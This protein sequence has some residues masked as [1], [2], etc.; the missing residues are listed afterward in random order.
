MRNIQPLMHAV[1]YETSVAVAACSSAR[2]AD[3]LDPEGTGW[4]ARR[5]MRHATRH[6]LLHLCFM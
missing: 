5:C 6:L 1:L 4:R 2:D 3:Q